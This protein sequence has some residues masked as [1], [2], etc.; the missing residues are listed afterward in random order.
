MTRSQL[1][2]GRH[3]TV[4]FADPL[5]SLT[6]SAQKIIEAGSWILAT[7]GYDSLTYE[8]IAR[9]A[10]VNKSSIR[11]NFGSKAGVV[12][13][14][15]DA[16]IHDGCI[17]LSETLTE[18][19]SEERVRRAVQGVRGLSSAE[20]FRGFF[21]VLPHALRDP[22]LRERL[23]RLYEWRYKETRKWIGSNAADAAAPS[24]QLQVGIARLMT[25]IID[26]LSI[27]V[28]LEII[29]EDCDLGPPLEA[30]VFLLEGV[31]EELNPAGD[32]GRR[33]P[34]TAASTSDSGPGSSH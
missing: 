10:G 16:M 29:P 11:N 5:G 25:A 32:R 3:Y 15:V 9:V 4:P 24:A 12:A 30:L 17:E 28:A 2:E 13:A 18:A 7:E 6:K 8:R 34:S 14:V 31:P 22:E 26:G 23:C 1:E 21:D 19:G 27:Q 20:T 33:A